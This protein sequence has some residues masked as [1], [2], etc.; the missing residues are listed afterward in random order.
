MHHVCVWS[1]MMILL[2]DFKLD[3]ALIRT[4]R[5][6]MGVPYYYNTTTGASSWNLPPGCSDHDSGKPWVSVLLAQPLVLQAMYMVPKTRVTA[7]MWGVNSS[8]MNSN[9]D[10]EGRLC[11]IRQ[12]TL[13]K[14]IHDVTEIVQ[15]LIDVN[16]GDYL[17]IDKATD[18]TP[19]FYDPSNGRGNELFLQFSVMGK[20]KRLLTS[21]IDV[22]RRASRIDSAS[23]STV[24]DGPPLPPPGLRLT[25]AGKKGLE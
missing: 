6:D 17:R 7:A 3:F 14:A 1:Y 8:H 2:E 19:L 21:P 11:D 4:N 13:P 18:L 15:G 5:D 24:A 25:E 10:S 22:H 16:S 9:V 12:M 23:L 20:E